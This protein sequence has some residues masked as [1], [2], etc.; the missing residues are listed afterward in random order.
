MLLERSLS[1]SHYEW[2]SW[3]LKGP[4]YEGGGGCVREWMGAWAIQKNN[5]FGKRVVFILYYPF[6][7]G[8]DASET[9]QVPLFNTSSVL[10]SS[11]Y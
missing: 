6:S 7:Q 1:T 9:P 3:D 11:P 2:T 8:R 5:V 10:P 4:C